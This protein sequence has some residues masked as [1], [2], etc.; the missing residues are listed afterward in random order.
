MDMGIFPELKDSRSSEISNIENYLNAYR[1]QNMKNI[2]KYDTTFDRFATLYENQ[3]Q[4]IQMQSDLLKDHMQQTEDELDLLELISEMNKLCVSKY[5]NDIPVISAA[6]ENI[7]TCIAKAKERL[8]IA[9]ATPKQIRDNLQA[10][11]KSTFE[12]NIRNCYKTKNDSSLFCITQEVSN[13]RGFTNNNKHKFDTEM[14]V[15]LFQANG[16]VKTASDCSFQIYYNSTT[17]TAQVKSNIGRC[18]QIIGG[19]RNSSSEFAFK[20]ED[21]TCDNIQAVTTNAFDFST[22]SVPNTLYRSNRTVNC[23]LLKVV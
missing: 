9:L 21:N 4:T 19:E 13:S 8:T 3:L 12:N 23:L 5:R 22:I 17:A 15:A 6:V 18:L 10:Y 1:R 7:T 2:E 16:Q 14:D 20:S 11:Y